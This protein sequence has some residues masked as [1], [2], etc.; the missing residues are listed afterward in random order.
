M[1]AE[2]HSTD[3]KKRLPAGGKPLCDHLVR[4]STSP[5]KPAWARLRSTWPGREK[6]GTGPGG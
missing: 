4:A 3:V 5:A 6:S 1:C 2:C